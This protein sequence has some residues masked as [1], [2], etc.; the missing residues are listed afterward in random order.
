VFHGP[1]RTS[2]VSPAATAYR[3]A[4]CSVFPHGESEHGRVVRELATGEEEPRV[5]QGIL[6]GGSLAGLAG[7]R[8]HG[9]AD[10]HGLVR[11][12]S[13]DRIVL[14]RRTEGGRGLYF[15]L[16]VTIDRPPED[17]FDF[18]AY[19]DRYPQKPGSPVLRA[20]EADGKALR[21]STRGIGSRPDAPSGQEGD[22]VPRHP[23]RAAQVLEE[24]FV[25]P[26]PMRVTLR[27]NSRQQMA[28]HCL[29]SERRLRWSD[30]GGCFRPSWNACSAGS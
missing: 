6:L 16:S 30:L 10:T 18:L 13:T 26:G 4:S 7:R 23:L 24:D 2:A 8:H 17:V 21:A 1:L 9:H 29:S 22:P 12:S 5:G 27:T 19:K 14:V 15:D 11:S 20:R 28:A 3:G 25:G